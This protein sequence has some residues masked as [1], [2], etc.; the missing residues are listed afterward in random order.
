MLRASVIPPS[1]AISSASRSGPRRILIFSVP[2]GPHLAGCEPG[3]EEPHRALVGHGVRKVRL[4]ESVPAFCFQPGLLL[5]LALGGAQGLLAL[6]AAA[7]RDLPRVHLQ[8]VAVLPDEVDVVVFDG[9]DPDGDVLVVHDAVDARLT[10]RAE[11]PGPRAP[12]SRGSRR[13]AW[14]RRSPTGCSC[15]SA[16]RSPSQL[17]FSGIH[18]KLL[19]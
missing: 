12:R 7:F 6:R 5:E 14:T 13:P 19:S 17:W 1:S 8:R 4:P 9:E 16:S 10:V 2:L 3:R 15:P 18:T 11:L